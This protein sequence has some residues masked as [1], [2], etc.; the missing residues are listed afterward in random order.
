[1]C[2]AV[3]QN[4]LTK[5]NCHLHGTYKIKQMVIVFCILFLHT[6]FKSDAEHSVCILRP[7][8]Y[9]HRHRYA[10]ENKIISGRD[11]IVLYSILKNR[12]IFEMRN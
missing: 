5:P 1:M 12:L 7:L 9:R 10:T 8:V 2:G 3:G 6:Y 11:R 4:Q